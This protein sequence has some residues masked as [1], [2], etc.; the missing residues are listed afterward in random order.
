[1]KIILGLGGNLGDRA[2]N[3]RQALAAI[4][5]L[6]GTKIIKTSRLYETEPFDVLS[7]QP[8]YLNLCA[9]VETDIPPEEFL[10]RCLGIETDLGRVRLEYHGART[11]DIDVL[12]CEDFE[13]HT[14][15]LTV[16]HPRMLERAFV[17]VPLCDLFPEGNAL[18]VDFT[19]ALERVDKSGVK[20]YE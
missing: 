6:S 11:V 8:P 15:A 2:E 3:L 20:V 7:E 13:S 10:S 16:P 5:A 17:L 18:G 9:L 12:V 14:P 1:M 4:A 19:E